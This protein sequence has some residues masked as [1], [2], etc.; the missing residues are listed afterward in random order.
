MLVR[1]PDVVAAKFSVQV[2][3]V[4]VVVQLLDVDL[5]VGFGFLHVGVNSLSN[6]YLII[7]KKAKRFLLV[8]GSENKTK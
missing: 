6:L 4:N 1:L 5:G 8:Y 3:L 2:V 7:Y